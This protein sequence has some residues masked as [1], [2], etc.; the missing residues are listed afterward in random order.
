MH[1]ENFI[2]FNMSNLIT[3]NLMVLI[4]ALIL[5]LFAVF[6]HQFFGEAPKAA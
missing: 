3:I 5:G 1:A 4:G 2:G 6:Y